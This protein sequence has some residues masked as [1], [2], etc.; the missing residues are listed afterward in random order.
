MIC[1]L[2]L[3]PIVLFLLISCSGPK[4]DH[5]AKVQV[6]HM[7]E[8]SIYD[9]KLVYDVIFDSEEYDVDSIKNKSRVLFLQGIDQ[10]KNKKD[11]RKA[12]NLFKESILIF[13]DAK[14]YYELGNAFLDFNREDL[15]KEAL[16]AYRV[17][18]YLDFQP[19]FNLYYKE[20]CANNILYH[21]ASTEEEKSDY[22]YETVS[23]LRM[24]FSNGFSDTLLLKNDVRIKSITSQSEYKSMLLH[25][26]IE[27]GKG[28]SNALFDLF[29]NAFPVTQ[30]AVFEIDKTNV[31]MGDYDESI[32]YDFANFIPEME[33]TGFGR[34][35]THD[36]FYVAKIAETPLYTALVY[37]SMSFYGDDMQPVRATL[38]TFN[39]QGEIIAKKIIACQCSAEKI[40]DAKIENNIVTIHDYKRQWEHAMGKVDLGKNKIIGYDLQ[41]TV[42]YKIEDTGQIVNEDVPANYKDSTVASK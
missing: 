4:V 17:A 33:N 32:S 9:E 14:T 30:T 41:A 18:E 19:K 16:D 22:L 12:I 35:V 39:P 36:Y 13:P 5:I 29:K 6:L 27:K 38:V 20:A 1:R 25:V 28:S 11:I 34:E 3:V 21:T 8:E 40:K 2:I 26:K 10:Y 37:K 24:A 23:N 15:V 42:K 31:E 7:T